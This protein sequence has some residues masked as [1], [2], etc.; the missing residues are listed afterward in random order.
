MRLDNFDLN[1]LVAFDILLQERNVTRAA[2]RLNVTQS[3]MSAALKRLREALHDEILVQHG[4]AMIPT[5][6][7]LALAPEVSATIS[8]LRSLISAR[9]G[10]DPASSTRRFRIAAS[11]Y[12]TTVLLVPLLRVIAREAPLVTLDVSLPTETCAARLGDGG[13]DLFLTPEEFTQ[14]EQPRELIF[15][16]HFVVVGWS[17]NPVMR[18]P[19]TE[20]AFAA[21]GHVDVRIDGRTTFVDNALRG[22]AVERRIELTAPSFL[23]APFMLPETSRIALMHER[24]ARMMAPALSLTIAAPPFPIPPMREMMQFH[25]TRANDPGLIW[26]RNSIREIAAREPDRLAADFA[27]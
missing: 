23:Q 17:G 19:L 1:L 21:S 27:P 4:K 9:T 14:A 24:L 10:F 7:A 22:L 11:D 6:N 16:E 5:P 26:L 12:I 8:Q 15:E 13:L 2:N 25:A 3:A 20:A 18:K